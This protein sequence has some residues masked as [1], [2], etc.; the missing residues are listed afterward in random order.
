M[1]LGG[2]R[3]TAFGQQSFGSFV[4]WLR[5]LELPEA[6]PQLMT[7][8]PALKHSKGLAACSE[9]EWLKTEGVLNLTGVCPTFRTNKEEKDSI[10]ASYHTKGSRTRHRTYHQSKH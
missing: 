5:E 3:M 1:E 2:R 6:S 8:R 9:I 10:C 4:D 7:M